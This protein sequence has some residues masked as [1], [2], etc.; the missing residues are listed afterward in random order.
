M[1]HEI[2]PV[3]LKAKDAPGLSARQLDEHHG[4][5]YK[6]YVSK[7]NEIRSGLDSA[8]RTKANQTYS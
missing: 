6:G 5:L 2:K 4:V 7:L 1:S 3:D 8:D